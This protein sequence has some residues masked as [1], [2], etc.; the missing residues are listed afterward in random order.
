MYG[1]KIIGKSYLKMLFFSCRKDVTPHFIGSTVLESKGKKDGLDYY[2]IIDGQQR[3]TTI[4]LA[5]IAIM[6]LLVEYGMDDDYYG[7]LEYIRVKNNRNQKMSILYLIIIF[8]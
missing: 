3:I 7:T 6:K 4:V 2:T 5:L 1:M 8:H